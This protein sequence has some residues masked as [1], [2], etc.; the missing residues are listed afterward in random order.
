MGLDKR[1]AGGSGSRPCDY[2]GWWQK[3]RLSDAIEYGGRGSKAK[4]LSC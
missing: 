2:S 4:N 1:E 3:H